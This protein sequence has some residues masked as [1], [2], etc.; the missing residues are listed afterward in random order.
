M[1][2]PLSWVFC[3]CLLT[4]PAIYAVFTGG[5]DSP[6]AFAVT[7]F[8]LGLA[9]IAGGVYFGW[10]A[11]ALSG[12]VSRTYDARKA[13]EGELAQQVQIG[14]LSAGAAFTV[15]GAA[16]VY[17]GWRASHRRPRL[18]VA[19]VGDSQGATVTLTGGW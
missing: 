2:R 8:D 15:A 17:L 12:Q 18:T 13:S 7:V 6:Y 19:P 9:G 1:I 4:L 11:D 16:L 3:L 10:R 5:A 14:S